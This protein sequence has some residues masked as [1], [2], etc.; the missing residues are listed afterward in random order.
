MEK[1]YYDQDSPG[2]ENLFND[3]YFQNK[4]LVGKFPPA[5]FEELSYFIKECRTYKDHSYGFLRNHLNAGKNGYQISVPRTV[6]E[7]SLCYPFIIKIGEHYLSQTGTPIVP[8]HRNVRF[9]CNENH[10]DAYDL[11]V[12]F[13]SSG[14]ENPLHCHSGTLSAVIYYANVD[15]VPT[16]FE[17]GVA[18]HGK[19]GDVIV[20][21]S[22][23]RHKVEKHTLT[24][25]RITLSFNL[26]YRTR[27]DIF[28]R[29]E[30]KF[31]FEGKIKDNQPVGLTPF[32]K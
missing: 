5:L 15:S 29:I 24:A 10:F 1:N 31:N 25:E 16:V 2:I 28:E 20:F 19:P 23:Y 27:W 26:E 3:F 4:L 32:P 30:H 17:D 12:N 14:D 7:N 11:W 8:R 18:F 22:D 13:S 21:P 9:R 6:V